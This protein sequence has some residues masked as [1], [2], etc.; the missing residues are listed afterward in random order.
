M[1]RKKN[2]QTQTNVSETD[3]NRRYKTHHLTIAKR[4]R[5]RS[6][7]IGERVTLLGTTFCNQTTPPKKH[8]SQPPKS[9]PSRSTIVVFVPF[10]PTSLNQCWGY[11]H[12]HGL[13]WFALS[14]SLSLSQ[15]FNRFFHSCVTFFFLVIQQT[16]KVSRCGG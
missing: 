6:I 13:V 11:K 1:K 8:K 7:L 10:A 9:H 14:L 16:T 3:A 15:V 4:P 12:K 5:L 2:T